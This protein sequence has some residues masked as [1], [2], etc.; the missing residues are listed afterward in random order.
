VDDKVLTDGEDP[1]LAC[2]VAVAGGYSTLD[3]VDLVSTPDPAD[4][5]VDVG[6]AVVSVR[7]RFL[8]PDMFRV[9]VRRARGRAVSVTPRLNGEKLPF[10]E[11]GVTG[12]L[13]RKRAWWIERQAWAVYG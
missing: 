11:D 2:A 6:I 12:D 8:R 13:T 3:G 9:E 4:G 10:V 1:V 5:L 7:K